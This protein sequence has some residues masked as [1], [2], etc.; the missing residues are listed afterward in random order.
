MRCIPYP[1]WVGSGRAG[2]RRTFFTVA[3]TVWVRAP[4]R[5]RPRGPAGSHLSAPDN[6]QGISGAALNIGSGYRLEPYRIPAAAGGYRDTARISIDG[7]EQ[8]VTGWHHAGPRQRD[9]LQDAGAAE[10]PLGVSS[11]EASCS[12]ERQEKGR[13]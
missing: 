6:E 2:A 13:Q 8:Q 3:P 12:P 4:R 7:D 9:P 1:R 11:E 5:A 10:R